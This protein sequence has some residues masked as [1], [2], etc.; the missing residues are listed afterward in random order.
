[1]VSASTRPPVTP[2]GR[3][4]VVRERLWRCANPALSREER[5]GLV[6]ALMEARPA[7]GAAM[8]AGDAEARERA[9]AAV[10]E[11][12]RRLGERGEV[13]WTDGA[14]DWNRYMVRNTPYAEWHA[15]LGGV[16][17]NFA[18]VFVGAGCILEVG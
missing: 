9:R 15:G 1:M 13:W 16:W 4:F 12:K 3:Y 10:D 8:R 17:I 7:K 6:R 2:D 18:L 5:E 11:A 14:K